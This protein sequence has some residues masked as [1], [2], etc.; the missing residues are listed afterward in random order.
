M[1]AERERGIDHSHILG[2]FYRQGPSDLQIAQ[3][4]LQARGRLIL[5]QHRWQFVARLSSLCRKCPFQ[6][7]D[8]RR[9]RDHD[10]VDCD[11]RGRED[12]G[13]EANLHTLYG[14]RPTFRKSSGE[15]VVRVHR[16]THTAFTTPHLRRPTDNGQCQSAT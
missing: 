2:F 1:G 7:L 14:M 8:R 12:T 3:Y 10:Q 4:V 15:Q 13:I 11:G 5:E 16:T 6:R 9:C